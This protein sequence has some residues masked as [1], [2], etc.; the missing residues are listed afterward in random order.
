MHCTVAVHLRLRFVESAKKVDKAIGERDSAPDERSFRKQLAR[1][2]EAF[3]AWVRVSDEWTQHAVSCDECSDESPKTSLP[4]P[5]VGAIAVRAEYT[6][7]L[8]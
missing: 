1:A 6:D 8:A 5:P 4:A 7:L 3:E 2:E